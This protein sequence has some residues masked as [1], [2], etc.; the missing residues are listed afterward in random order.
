M[1]TKDDCRQHNRRVAKA[2]MCEC[3]A[4]LETFVHVNHGRKGYFICQFCA[5]KIR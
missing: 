2:F 5:R 1:T 4:E 3:G